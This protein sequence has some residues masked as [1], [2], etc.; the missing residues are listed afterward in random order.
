VEDYREVNR[1]WWDEAAPVHASSA[2][3]AL[4]RFAE[5]P[6]YLSRVVRFDLPRLGDVRGLAGVHLQC[7]IGTDTVSLARLGAEMVGLDFS[8]PALE[9]A[10]R[11]AAGAGV[12]ARFVAGDVYEAPELLGQDRF[13]LLYTGIRCARLAP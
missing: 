9:S 6:S 2:D 11:L 13:D 10:R 8:E 12:D 5:D 1:R 7:H 3:Y 4:A